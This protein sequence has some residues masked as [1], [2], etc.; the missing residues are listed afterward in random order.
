MKLKLVVASMSILGLASCPVFAAHANSNK[1][2]HKSHHVMAAQPAAHQDYKD[3]GAIPAA[4]PVEVC[5]LSQP[6]MVMDGMSQNLGR[7]M[8]NPCNPGWFNRIQ[9]SGGV[10]VDLGKFGSRNT[11]YMG[12]N[13]RRVSLNDAY[14]NVG[15]NINEWTKAFASINFQTATTITDGNG[16]GEYSAAYSNNINGNGNNN[17]EVE[18]AFATLANF[19]AEPFFVQV[20]KQ[21]QDFGRYEIH[22]ITRSLTQSMSETLATSLKAGFVANGFNG[23]V[24]VFDDALNKS[25]KS[26]SRTNFV[27]ALGYAL[28]SDQMG[29][30][31]GAGYIYNLAGVNDVAYNVV[32]MQNATNALTSSSS[33]SNGMFHS[34]K[35]GVAAYGDVN[36]GPF[37]LS[38]RYVQA[39]QRF[40]ASDLPRHG[41]SDFVVSNN[42][43][44]LVTN[45]NGAKPWSA[46]VQLGYGFEALG[47]KNNSVYAGYEVSKQAAA[48]NLPASRV[49]AGYGIEYWRN[50]NL[51]VEWDHDYAYAASKGGRG[52][53]TDLVSMR[54]AVKFG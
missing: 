43:A 42:D 28:A 19:D 52:R 32:N 26:T 41:L 36:S 1:H 8:P 31:L 38:A 40:N 22:P 5:T 16:F 12:E 18:Q 34:R 49:L 3:M 44:S 13:Y 4:A 27:A 37:A 47:C 17:V 48:L 54:A 33:T 2:H 53:T 21:F 7:A 25:S 10:N 15:A 20:G 11:A 35:S 39:L 50:T 14:V 9:V 45:A 24:S 6:Y 51:G 30:D 23:S 29:F 46:G